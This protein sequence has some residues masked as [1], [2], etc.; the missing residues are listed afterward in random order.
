MGAHY[1]DCVFGVPGVMLSAVRKNWRVVAV[2]LIGD[3]SNWPP[4]KGRHQQLVPSSIALAK[5]YGVE[6][7]FGPFSS[8]LFDNTAENRKAVARLISDLTP[9]AAFILWPHDHHDDHRVAS[10]LSEIAVKNAGQ[11]LGLDS[12]RGPR[13]LYA[14]DNGPRHTI[15]FEPDTFVDVT[16]EW[17]KAAEWLGRL[18]AIV[19][20]QRYDSKQPDGAV[21]TKEAIAAYRGKTCGARYAEAVSSYNRRARDILS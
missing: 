8:H 2:A 13:D 3:Y 11:I 9:D 12:W 16:G 15:G 1:D 19:R 10:Q 6:L 5:E 17:P 4:M 18:M 21:E 14:F 20:N 7:R